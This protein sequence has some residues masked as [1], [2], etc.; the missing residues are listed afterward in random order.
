MTSFFQPGSNDP[1]ILECAH[2]KF[3]VYCNSPIPKD[4]LLQS[5]Y[6]QVTLAVGASSLLLPTVL[7]VALL[8][9]QSWF[10]RIFKHLAERLRRKQFV[11]QN[12]GSGPHLASFQ[13]TRSFKVFMLETQRQASFDEQRSYDLAIF[14][15]TVG[16]LSGDDAWDGLSMAGTACHEVTNL[17][18]VDL[19]DMEPAALEPP[20]I[21]STT[22]YL[23]RSCI[24]NSLAGLALRPSS[25][26]PNKNVEQLLQRLHY[27]DV[28]VLLLCHHDSADIDS[29][30]FQY[31]SGVILE[32]AC[33]LPNGQRRDYFKAKRLREVMVRCAT[34]R[35]KRPGFFVGF[36]EMWENRPHPSVVRR[37]VKLAEHFGAVV[38]HGSA[39]PNAKLERPPRDA[40]FTLSSFEYLR[41]GDVTELQKSWSSDPRTIQ[42]GRSSKGTIVQGVRSLSLSKVDA[43]LPFA[44]ALLKHERVPNWLKASQEQTVAM[45]EPP[46]YLQE[47]PKRKDFWKYSADGTEMSPAGCFSILSEPSLEDYAAVL[48]TQ[49]HLRELKLLNAVKGAEVHRLIKSIQPLS[50]QDECREFI[51]DLINGLKSNNILIFRGLN[52]GFKVPDGNSYFQGVCKARDETDHPAIDIYISHSAPN[53]ASVVLHTWL[54]HHGVSRATCLDIETRLESLNGLFHG[55]RLPISIRSAIEAG[56]YAEILQLLQQMRVA[57]LE[58]HW[59]SPI[60]SFCESRLTTQT[61]RLSW[62]QTHARGILDGSISVRDMLLR[63]LEIYVMEGAS[64]LPLLENLE[65]LYEL[66]SNNIRD[67]LF[68]GDREKLNALTDALIDVFGSDTLGEAAEQ[69]D[70]NA[71]MFALMF[72]SIMRKEAFEEVY[73]ESTDRCPIF[74]C[75]DQAAVFSELWVLGS[76]CEIFLGV[77]P[78]DL[79]DI[80]YDRYRRF[81]KTCPPVAADRNGNEIMT[82]YSTTEASPPSRE[83]KSKEENTEAVSQGLSMHERFELWKKHFAAVGAI[84]I[85]SLPAIIDVLLLTFLGRGLFMTAFMDPWHIE[86]AAYALLISLLLTAGVTGWVGS[87]GSYYLNHYAYENMTHFHVQRLSGGFMLT[88][89]VAIGGFICF[90][91]ANS[92]TT[93][94]VFVAYVIV[95]TTYL[96]LLGVMATMHQ[97]GSPVTSGRT[98]LWRTIPLLFISPVLTSVINGHDVAI[99]LPI[100]CAT[101]LLLLYQYRRLCHEWN[102]WMRNIPNVTEKDMLAWFKSK[103][104]SINYDNEAHPD[105]FSKMAQEALHDAVTCYARRSGDSSFAEVKND[106]FVKHVAAG[107]PYIDWLFKKTN[108]NGNLPDT[109][110]SGWYTQLGG[111]KKQQEQLSRGLKEH[112]I[113]ML[114]RDAKYDLGQNVGLFLI[115]LMDRWVN[116]IMNNGHPGRSI[117][118][119]SR[120]RYAVCL[121]VL[122]FLVGVVVLDLTLQKHWAFRFTLSKDKLV[123]HHHAQRVAHQWERVRHQKL[124]AA[125]L[126]LFTRLLFLFGITTLL[127]WMLVDNPESILLYY[128]Y[129]A[130]YTGVILFQFNRCFTTNVHGHVFIILGS[131]IVGFIVG[132]VLHAH[133][134]SAEWLYSD[135]VGQNVAALLAAF[136]TLLWTW[137]DWFAPTQATPALQLSKQTDMFYAQ[138]KLEA[139]PGI[140][141][142]MSIRRFVKSSGPRFRH[143]DGSFLSWKIKDILITSLMTPN[144]TSRAC[145]WASEFIQIAFQAWEEGRVEIMVVDRESFLDAGL[146]HLFSFSQEDGDVLKITAGFFGDYELRLPAWQMQLAQMIAESLMYHVA[147]VEI[148]L[149]HSQAVHTEHFLHGTSPMSKRIQ[150]ELAL[151]D[152]DTLRRTIHQTNTEMLRRLALDVNVDL[153]WHTLPPSVREVIISRITGREVK[154]T[155]EFDDWQTANNVDVDT[156][157]FHLRLTLEI[158]RACKQRCDASTDLSLSMDFKESLP[159]AELIPVKIPSGMSGVPIRGY[160]RRF[161]AVPVTFAR[162]VALISGGGSNIERELC[163]ALR[164]LPFKRP[165]VWIILRIWKLCWAM[166]NFWIYYF[167]IYHRSAVARLVRLTRKGALRI[168]EK[169]S[170]IVEMSRKTVTGFATHNERGNLVLEV[171]EGRL[172]EAPEDEPPVF[173]ATYDDKLR[174]KSRTDRDGT[175]FTYN[176]RSTKMR[177]WPVSRGIVGSNNRALGLYDKQGRLESGTMMLGPKPLAFF[178]HYKTTPENSSD[179]LRA[180]F[181]LLD[182]SSDDKLSVFWGKPLS[183]GA[184]CYNWAPSEKIHRIVRVTGGKTYAT[185]IEY[186]HR[187]DPKSLTYLVEDGVYKTI[188]AV[189]PKVFPQE[190]SLLC[191][192]RNILFDGDDLLIH[193]SVGQ[194][195][196]MRQYATKKLS[197]MSRLSSLAWW[198]RRVHLPVATWLSRT[199]LWNAWLGGSLDAVTACWIDEMILRE[200]PLL[201]KYWRA[202]DSGNLDAARESLEDID[203]IVAAIE[204]ETDVSE[205]CLL[206][207]RS[208]D[209]FAMGLGKDANQVT[210][211]PQD[212]YRDTKDRVSVIVNDIGCWPEAPGGVSNCRRDLVN[213][214]GTIRNH[215]MAECAN[216]FGIPRFQIERNVQ[217]LK[218]LPLWGLDGKTANHGLIDNILQSEVDDHICDTD[219]Q[220]DIARVFVPLLKAFVKGAR[221]K[222]YTRATLAACTN[223]MLSMSKYFESKD[224]NKTWSSKQVE[225]AWVEAWLVS[226]EDPNIQDPSEYFDIARPTLFDFREALGIYIAYLFIFSVKIP[227]ECP[228]VF[229]STHHGISSLLGIILKYRRGVA[230]GIWD[231]AILW[232]ESCLNISPAQCELPLSVQ[233]MLLHG[234]RLASRLSYFHA[235]VI[236]PCTSLFNPMWETEIG[237]DRGNI[238]NRNLF[239]RKIDPIVNG[240]SNMDSFEPIDKVRTD[241]PTA[242][243]LSNVQFIKGIKTAILAADII[244]NRYGFKD[245]RLMVYGAKDRQPSY[246]LEMAKLIVKHNLSDNVILAGFGKPKEVLKDA[247]IFMNSSI[248]EGLPLAIGEAALAGVPIVATEVGATALVMTDPNDAELRYGEVVAPNDPVALA[249]AQLNILCMIG[250]WTKFLE[251]KSEPPKTLPEE[252]TAH[253][254]QRLSERMYSK[255][256]DR[257]KLGLLSR[258]VVLES[259]HGE[260]YLREHEQMYWIQWHTARMRADLLKSRNRRNYTEFSLPPPMRYI[261]ELT[262]EDENGAILKDAEIL[263]RSI[264][265]DAYTIKEKRTLW[266]EDL[267]AQAAEKDDMLRRSTPDVVYTGEAAQT[268]ANRFT[269]WA[270]G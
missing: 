204:I 89:L 243:M 162:W 263:E 93:G 75:A 26:T 10:S 42:L 208:A 55:S 104:G 125:L 37:A 54:A 236:T 100:A 117:Y 227:E 156:I 64:E 65:A 59:K 203:Q 265:R 270:P 260:R 232:R 95:V 9:R 58:D 259:F 18:Y 128:L 36:S 177:T 184:E 97:T 85:F 87:T 14:P 53:D 1:A 106:T 78:R 218:L 61:S 245:Y 158:F 179:I 92:A 131:S 57:H 196:I 51:N 249:R 35:R 123:D 216:E 231:H 24:R 33:I 132:C 185:E 173:K 90:T 21:A 4:N 103:L 45:V 139:D 237:S 246:A 187:R 11:Y 32:N 88:M 69:V 149:T 261:D 8:A 159:A 167:L 228:R 266:L 43:A 170:I 264:R 143:D 235:D 2:S 96:N 169:N 72:F 137:K 240:I 121:C 86:A 147:R 83:P 140:E 107:M 44:S 267:E 242:V 258:Q 144:S 67:A 71:D 151:A 38:E 101:I 5:W 176:Y 40:A 165:V 66:M 215:V 189:V 251:D 145:E 46:K 34:E 214:H 190:D 222:D 130:G 79:G 73:I 115:A 212:C 63:R 77:L 224:Y 70:V 248:S 220:R 126:E 257:R 183:D 205:V 197:I 28:S 201:R 23:V 161:T 138:R 136:G 238:C 172:G 118:T 195:N 223:V 91:I 200:E 112:N 134:M 152:V 111:S 182:S 27:C 108:P 191:R 141:S 39:D 155:K 113:L 47:A 217:S 268:A 211:R 60:K 202:R 229:Q 25:T 133:P 168:I 262:A 193:H 230:F 252:I 29:L 22:E 62:Y 269:N 221:T 164:W 119:D 244:V 256:G 41:R 109:F 81:L 110:S 254:V 233:F 199:E 166:R 207:I 142:G 7:F 3:A 234:I 153:A 82:M 52:T 198:T 239:S 124:V 56:T 209:L 181:Q 15:L 192:P 99:Y 160:F 178:Y 171:F 241:R 148:G 19:K 50:E 30:S 49:C 122:Y 76:Q 150:F 250:P 94:L 17:A 16:E 247:W 80:I 226:Y 74:L 188:V 98:V 102:G 120:A 20:D 175:T 180:D 157:D 127:L 206:P 84:T 186:H 219:V 6:Q 146:Q 135:V 13:S 210:N 68:Y 194:I 105:G 12:V 31:A 213:G 116:V 154:L 225:D 48:E 114:F 129:V 255:A 174:L 253:D 163:Y